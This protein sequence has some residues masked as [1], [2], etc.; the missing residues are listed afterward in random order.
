[1][2]KSGR[3][4]MVESTGRYSGTTVVRN[5]AEKVL[6]NHGK[7]N[8]AGKFDE[9]VNKMHSMYKATLL[10]QDQLEDV[11]ER[12]YK[13]MYESADPQL[14]ESLPIKENSKLKRIARYKGFDNG[15]VLHNWE[16]MT[17]A[18]AEELAKQASIKDP[19]DIYYVA[20][21]DVMDASSDIRWI[22]GK[23]YSYQDVQIRGDK[24]FIKK[25]QLLH[26]SA[27]YYVSG[28]TGDPTLETSDP[29]KA[30]E[31]WFK[32]CRKAKMMASIHTMKEADGI[33]LLKWAASNPDK[34]TTWHK[35]YNCPY[36]LDYILDKSK[37][38]ADS[39]RIAGFVDTSDWATEPWEG[40]MIAVFSAG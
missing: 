15:H 23:P 33:K 18:K 11:M 12:E 22:A 17:A 26:E 25:D 1:M 3:S 30:V 28:K 6:K 19:N 24:P 4:E 35:K 38:V 21:D 13:K 39:G 31:H 36:N 9:F 34:V 37:Q 7:N 20:Y 40:D 32:I 14:S 27:T 8:G 10:D 5:T 29:A 16:K 2:I